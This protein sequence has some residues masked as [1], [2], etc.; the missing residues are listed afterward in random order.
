MNSG[1]R[2][3][4]SGINDLMVVGIFLEEVAEVL[5]KVAKVL[6]VVDALFLVLVVN[7]FL[8]L[9]VDW[10]VADGF[11]VMVVE[12]VRVDVRVVK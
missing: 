4:L 1:A 10:L 11:L 8:V 2:A 12:V 3:Q 7:L 9:V 6:V 5:V